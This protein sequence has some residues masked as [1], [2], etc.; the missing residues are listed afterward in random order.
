MGITTEANDIEALEKTLLAELAAAGDLGALEEFRVA[1]LGKKGRIPALMKT[2]GGMAPDE[3]KA[4]GQS[5]NGLK[6]RVS[7]ALDARKAALG[8]AA[9]EA[10]LATEMA[11]VTLPVRP[12]PELMGRIHPIS[13]VWDELTEIFADMGFSVAEGP[14]I[15]TEELNFD[16]LNIPPS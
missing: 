7:D 1:A 5:V 10:R 16:K 12:G 6:Q 11:D 14:D 8:D 15:E 3:R 2:L 9:L 4:F 13:Q